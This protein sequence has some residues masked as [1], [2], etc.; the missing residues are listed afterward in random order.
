MSAAE[1]FTDASNAPANIVKA[2]K[3]LCKVGLFQ[4]FLFF[5]D[6]YLETAVVPFQGG[7]WQGADGPTYLKDRK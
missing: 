6:A 3:V 2:R 4:P 5:L 7:T 1:H